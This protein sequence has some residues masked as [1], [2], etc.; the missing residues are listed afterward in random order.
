M[1]HEKSTNKNSTHS[2]INSSTAIFNFQMSFN[3]PPL[4][5]IWLSPN[6]EEQSTI[7]ARKV[8]FFSVFLGNIGIKV[9]EYVIYLEI[10]K[11]K[12]QRSLSPDLR[13]KI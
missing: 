3:S 11:N 13:G 8:N 12:E 2:E 4:Y 9:Q 1:R 5:C 6:K 10:K 7:F